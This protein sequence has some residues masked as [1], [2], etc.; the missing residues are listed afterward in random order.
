MKVLDETADRRD[1]GVWIAHRDRIQ[2]AEVHCGDILT[3]GKRKKNPYSGAGPFPPSCASH[4]NVRISPALCRNTCLAAK[5]WVQHPM[6][7]C[8]RR[9]GMLLGTISEKT[10]RDCTLQA[11]RYPKLKETKPGAVLL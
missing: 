9:D 4:I 11:R 6:A 1:F 10:W 2:T 8:F 5:L 7:M 3:H